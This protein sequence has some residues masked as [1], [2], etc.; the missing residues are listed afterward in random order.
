VCG[1]CGG[2]LQVPIHGGGKRGVAVKTRKKTR[3]EAAAR[4][5][6]RGWRMERLHPFSKRH[7]PSS[8]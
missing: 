5:E 4:I 1:A 6:D 8:R 7:S 2:E 3:M